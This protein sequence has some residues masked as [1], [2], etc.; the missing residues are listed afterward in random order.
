MNFVIPLAGRSR[1]FVEAG[2]EGH[3][4]FLQAH[5]RSL[6]EWSVASLPLDVANR[7]VFIGLREDQ[8][9]FNI[10]EE[11]LK[12][13]QRYSGRISF[14]WLPEPTSG[15]AATVSAG[16][17][18]CA[19][20]EPLVIFNIDTS[21][22][23]SQLRER[24]LRGDWA[25]FVGS[26]RSQ[27]PAFSYAELNEVGKVIRVVEKEVVSNVAL[28]GLYAFRSPKEFENAFSLL[29]QGVMGEKGESFVAPL[30]QDLIDRGEVV[31]HQMAEE[32][33]I[34]GTPA[35]YEKF[36]KEG[37]DFAKRFSLEIEK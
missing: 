34:L 8:D 15:Q 35:D 27:D 18:H 37:H 4:A 25:G 33:W 11:V 6:L 13:F 17:S 16:I 1:R 29:N 22:L 10:E 19:P 2:Y 32:N 30:Y 5:G 3:K 36:L 24:L 23:D 9:R 7:I 21:F 20:D 28:N 12:S 26:F 31:V 14:V